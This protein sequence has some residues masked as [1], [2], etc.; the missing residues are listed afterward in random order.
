MWKVGGQ[1]LATFADHQSPVECL[2]VSPS[3]T[4]ILSGDRAGKLFLWNAATAAADPEFARA[5][6]SHPPLGTVNCVVISG[7]GTQA[8]SG[9]A[10]G[11]VRVWTLPGGP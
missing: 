10:G 6:E 2:A 7:D 3:G 4:R 5:A 11:T 8:V 1:P 9:H